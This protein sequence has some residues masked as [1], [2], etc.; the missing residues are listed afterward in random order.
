MGSVGCLLGRGI[1]T[2]ACIEL[3][4]ELWLHLY[5]H[6]RQLIRGSVTLDEYR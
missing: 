2:H 6:P 4:K 3:G 1:T 5:A